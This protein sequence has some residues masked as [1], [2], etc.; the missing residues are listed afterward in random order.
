MYLTC[1]YCKLQDI[2]LLCYKAS[3]R[4]DLEKSLA[5][6]TLVKAEI[7]L[8]NAE[9]HLKIVQMN[10]QWIENDEINLKKLNNKTKTAR[11]S[12]TQI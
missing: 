7:H 10:L 9:I 6:I 2:H 11:F 5:E 3:F 4:R 12:A 1:T 8:E